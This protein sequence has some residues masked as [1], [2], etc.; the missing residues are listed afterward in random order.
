MP[1]SVSYAARPQAFSPG[2]MISG[3]HCRPI[4]QSS[5]PHAALHRHKQ[6]GIV[7][8]PETLRDWGVHVLP[9]DLDQLV[10]DWDVFI[11]S[12]LITT[13]LEWRWKSG[14][15][16][17]GVFTKLEKFSPTLKAGL[18]LASSAN[19]SANPL[20]PS[21]AGHNRLHDRYLRVS[22]SCLL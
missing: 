17:V 11:N 9:E 10:A 5:C 3:A 8:N 14:A 22:T 19:S 15:W 21:I 16:I 6:V 18:L 2:Q 7:K 13:Q 20:F 4:A 1:R 12:D